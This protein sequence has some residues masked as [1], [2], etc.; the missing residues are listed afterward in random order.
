MPMSDKVSTTETLDLLDRLS[1]LAAAD[2]WS[3]ELNP[4]QHTALNYLS[5]ANRFSRSPSHV[6]DYLETTRGTASQTLKALSR[7][8]LVVEVRSET[9]KRS[10]SY[11]LTAEGQA[12]S[13]RAGLL[14]NVLEEMKPEDRQVLASS[15]KQLVRGALAH[16]GGRSFGIC[17]TCRYHDSNP[18]GAFCTLLKLSLSP[19][20]T[21]RICHE[22]QPQR[23]TLAK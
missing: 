13:Q 3:T 20:D 7:K 6:A 4:S 22:H 18:E 16:R 9:D 10:I 15:L 17:R 8:G 5:R 1:R 19:E 2:E 21:G 11:T 23:E 14:T 12:M